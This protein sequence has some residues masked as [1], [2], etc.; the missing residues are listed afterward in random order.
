MRFSLQNFVNKLEQH[1]YFLGE[2]TSDAQLR[3]KQEEE[4]EQN[5]MDAWKVRLDMRS[6]RSLKVEKQNIRYTFVE[7]IKR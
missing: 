6:H 5:K 2:F 7:S 3:L 1:H 4:K